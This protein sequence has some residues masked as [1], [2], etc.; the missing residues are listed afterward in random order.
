MSALDRWTLPKFPSGEVAKSYAAIAAVCALGAT[1][2][3][4]GLAALIGTRHHAQIASKSSFRVKEAALARQTGLVSQPNEHKAAVAEKHAERRFAGSLT[5]SAFVNGSN[6]A[7]RAK[8]AING[9]ILDHSAFGT[10]VDLIAQE[11][12]WVKVYS[13]D[14]NI[15]GWI[16]RAHLSF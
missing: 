3:F 5:G 12:K 14:R 8:P 6:A 9:R 10:N 13:P 11:G 16:E 2:V 1:L 7:I 4:G 15:S